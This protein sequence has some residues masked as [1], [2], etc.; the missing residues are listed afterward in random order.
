MSEVF[1]YGATFWAGVLV[2]CWFAV[3]YFQRKDQ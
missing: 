3:G 2:G 1:L